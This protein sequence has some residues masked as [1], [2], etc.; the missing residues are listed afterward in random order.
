[1]GRENSSHFTIYEDAKDD[2][3]EEEGVVFVSKLQHNFNVFFS[4]STY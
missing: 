2:T 1:M 3:D 4:S